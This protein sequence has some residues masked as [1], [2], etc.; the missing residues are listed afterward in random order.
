MPIP[1]RWPAAGDAAT[2]NCIRAAGCQDGRVKEL[3][4]GIPP[5]NSRKWHRRR[6]GDSLGYI[7]VRSLSN[8]AWHRDI[9]WLTTVVVREKA[10]GAA[11]E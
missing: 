11:H 6:W 7:R 9:G 3:P 4:P 5:A 10:Y 1:F 8:P 2:C